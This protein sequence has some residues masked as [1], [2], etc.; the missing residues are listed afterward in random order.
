M[1]VHLMMLSQKNCK[2]AEAMFSVA[3]VQTITCSKPIR[4]NRKKHVLL[5]P[6]KEM[7]S[8]VSSKVVFYVNGKKVWT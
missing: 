6:G 8:T 2:Q 7:D 5:R 3:S 1:S 4:L